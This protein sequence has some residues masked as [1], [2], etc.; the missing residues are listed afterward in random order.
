M[1]LTVYLQL[2]SFLLHYQT[3]LRSALGKSAILRR[4]AF[5]K[6]QHQPKTFKL[7]LMKQNSP[8]Q[9]TLNLGKY[10]TPFPVSAEQKRSSPSCSKAG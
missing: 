7:T 9:R 8:K 10:K 5:L 4:F 6:S 3:P 2:S 1:P